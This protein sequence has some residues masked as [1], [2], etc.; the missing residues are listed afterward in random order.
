MDVTHHVL[1]NF[2]HFLI[3][4]GCIFSH[5]T[6]RNVQHLE[7]MNVLSNTLCFYLFKR[8]LVFP[9]F[10]CT[11]QRTCSKW[12][13]LQI[14]VTEQHEFLARNERLI[15]KD[16][17]LH[18][19]RTE[20][21]RLLKPC[22]LHNS[23]PHTAK[24]TPLVLPLKA[25][26]CILCPNRQL[27]N[28]N[29]TIVVFRTCGLKPLTI[30]FLVDREAIAIEAYTL[31]NKASPAMLHIIHTLTEKF[32]FVFKFYFISFRNLYFP[33]YTGNHHL[34]KIQGRGDSAILC[35]LLERV[36][37]LWETKF[38]LTLFVRNPT[39]D[40]ESVESLFSES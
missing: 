31:T 21:C 24:I 17:I 38:S 10:V 4:R 39:Y 3:F 20:V 29:Q 30:Y 27:L 40:I 34:Y 14:A 2:I 36:D 1:V 33:R 18:H 8:L 11:N 22:R 25:D 16:R 7:T 37:A 13:I 32:S 26:D 19:V 12:I 23:L 35:H 6:R 15:T 28:T 5:I 9:A